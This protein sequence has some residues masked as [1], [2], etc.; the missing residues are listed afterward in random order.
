[1]QGKKNGEIQVF[2]HDGLVQY[3]KRRLLIFFR[4]GA[5]LLGRCTYS[6]MQWRKNIFG[7]VLICNTGPEN[8][9]VGYKNMWKMESYFCIFENELI[10]ESKD[11]HHKHKTC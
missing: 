8:V 3:M 9:K 11:C 5:H 6:I 1:M 2:C 10:Y 4:G 7:I